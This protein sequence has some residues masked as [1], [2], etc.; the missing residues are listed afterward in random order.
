MTT[1]LRQ[2]A[3][4]CGAEILAGDPDLPIDAAANIDDA[5]PHQLTFI[6]NT[7]HLDKLKATSAGAVIVPRG[8]AAGAAPAATALLAVADPEIA[9]IQ[10]LRRL[11]PA[12]P[13]SGTRSPKADVDPSA[14]L[15]AGSCVEAFASIGP[16][17]RLGKDCHIHAG[18]RIGAGVT[19]GDRCV[20]HP[21]VV[22][23]DGVT[24][25]DEVVVH[26]GSV[27]GADGYGYKFRDGEHVKFPQV[28]TVEIG[29]QVEI[30]ANTCIDRGALGATRIG[31]GTKID[32]QVHVAHN[33]QVGRGALL[34]GQVGIGGSSVIGDYA[35][36]A[37]QCGVADHVTI[38]E[39]A[40]VLAQSG[41]TK[42]VCAHSQVMG[43]PAADRKAALRELAALGRLAAD[44]RAIEELVR[45]LPQLRCGSAG[46]DP[47]DD[48]SGTPGA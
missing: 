14:T 26:A 40:L 17:S 3:Q 32:N 10:C 39:R 1:T 46:P 29:N 20:L 13:H 43:F 21:N 28:G 27:I 18:C 23:Y 41:V 15:G 38:G 6:G 47:V 31:A 42:D 8:A 33:V 44:Q 25:G 16:G 11:Y 48:D 4:I 22:L 19:L 5:G 9:F 45:L 37:S 24:L 12:R 36:L 35:I 30:G 7:R 34:L 2:L